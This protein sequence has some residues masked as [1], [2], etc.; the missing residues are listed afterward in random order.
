MKLVERLIFRPYLGP[1]YMDETCPA[2]RV[3]RLGEIINCQCCLASQSDGMQ[4][5]HAYMNKR[6]IH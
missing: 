6:T 1:V 2:S 3:S 4:F 5:W